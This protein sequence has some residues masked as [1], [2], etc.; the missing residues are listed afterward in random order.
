MRTLIK[1]LL[2]KIDKEVTL[3]GWVHNIRD[4]GNLIFID[5]R[6]ESEIVQ[7]VCRGEDKEVF[8]IA[9]ALK[10]EFVI[11]VRGM[12]KKRTASTINPKIPLGAIEVV[13]RSLEIIN[14]CDKLPFPVNKNAKA[15]ENLRLKYRYLDLRTEEMKKNLLLRYEII[16]FIRHFMD[17]KGFIEIETPILTKGT[18]EGAREFLVPSRL[19]RGKFYVLPQSPQQFKQI[20]MVAGFGKY[21]QIAKCFRDEDLRGDRQPEFTQL[22]IEQSFVSQEEIM[23]LIEELLIKLTQRFFPH[24][25]LKFLPFKRISYDEALSKY[26]TDKPDLRFELEIEDISSIFPEIKKELIPSIVYEPKREKVKIIKLDKINLKEEDVKEL[27]QMVVNNRAKGIFLIYFEKPSTTLNLPFC[28]ISKEEKKLKE[29]LSIKKEVKGLLI[30]IGKEKILKKILGN[31]RLEV[32]KKLGYLEDKKN[33]LAFVWITEFPLFEWNST[34]RKFD[35]VHHPFTF[36][37]DEDLK[38]LE[39]QPLKVKSKAYDIVLNGVEIG[40]GSIRIHNANLQ[41]KI[42]KILGLTEKEI[43]QRFGHLLEALRYG[44]PPHGGIA[45]G[46]DRLIS[47]LLD[48]P[49]IRDI[50]AFPKNQSACDLLMG[51]PSSVSKRQLEEVGIQLTSKKRE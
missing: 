20:L 19:H 3:L 49:S 8:K 23:N 16:K 17:T 24:K 45:L 50:I 41:R 14:E 32:A 40:G 31:L 39:K 34:E 44:A 46:L 35:S 27:N 36:P 48:L 21:F 11:S 42:F 43:N 28:I 30:V 5:L 25:T 4:H 51:A 47:T 15:D 33:Q 37:K 13:A 22:D 38:I 29:I 6:D 18:P 10:E 26:G 1:T 7:V 2:E 9:K 12:V